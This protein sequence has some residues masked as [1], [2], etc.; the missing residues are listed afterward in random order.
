[1]LS[2]SAKTEKTRYWEAVCWTVENIRH[3]ECH[4]CGAM[5]N[6]IVHEFTDPPGKNEKNRRMRP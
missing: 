6:V 4:H 2:D 1:M 3:M 5:G